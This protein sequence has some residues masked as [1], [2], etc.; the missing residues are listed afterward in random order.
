LTIEVASLYFVDSDL[1]GFGTTV[2]QL[3]CASTVGYSTNINDCND[4]NGSVYPG[5][6]EICNGLDDNCNSQ[7]D[8]GV[9]TVFFIDNDSDN[10]GNASVAILGCTAPAGYTADNNDCNDTNAAINPGAQEILGNNIDDNCDGQID[11]SIDELSASIGLYPNPARSDLNIQI[12]AT[13]IGEKMY[14]FDVVGNLVYKQQ[15]L[16]TQ[17]TVSV[18]NLVNGNYIVRVGE[19]VKRFEV[20]K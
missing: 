15:L 3:V 9:Q 2:S 18:S 7:I 8:E 13:L 20:L 12:D 4:S 16:S 10:Y 6:T 17:T 19:L 11:I 5:A 1:D 14:I